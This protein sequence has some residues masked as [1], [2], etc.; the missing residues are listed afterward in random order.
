[1]ERDAAAAARADRARAQAREVLAQRRFQPTNV[2]AP[3]RGLRERIGAALRPLGGPFERAYRWIADGPLVVWALLAALVLAGAALLATRA[4]VRRARDSA[5]TAS[6]RGAAVAGGSASLS[7]VELR[8][9]ADRAERSG[10]LDDALR[11][12]FRAGL[13]DL[14]SRALIELRPALTNSELLRAVPS[15]TLAD[16]VEGFESV[17]YGGRPAGADDLRDAR[18]GW[19]RVADEVRA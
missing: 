9:A 6:S 18:D 17:A 7:A 15:P 13:V 5:R 2:P 11:L 3:L 8:E 14:D 1:M 19:P 12:R 10:D 4:G 16:L